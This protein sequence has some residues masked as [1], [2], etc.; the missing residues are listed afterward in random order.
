MFSLTE[1]METPTRGGARYET[2]RFSLAQ[3]RD[4]SFGPPANALEDDRV[5]IFRPPGLL[6]IH[7]PSGTRK[8]PDFFFSTVYSKM[9]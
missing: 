5:M 8:N 4:T 9:V 7:I 1:T 3:R 6:K 2:R